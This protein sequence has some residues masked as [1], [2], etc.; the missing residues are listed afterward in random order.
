MT[1][2]YHNRYAFAVADDVAMVVPNEEKV[3]KMINSELLKS[4][5]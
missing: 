5:K 1:R 2:H 3:R 4:N